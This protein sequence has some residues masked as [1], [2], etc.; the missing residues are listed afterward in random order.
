MEA[1]ASKKTSESKNSVKKTTPSTKSPPRRRLSR[2]PLASPDPPGLKELTSPKTP[3]SKTS[4]SHRRSF[5][6]PNTTIM[7]PL[8]QGAADAKKKADPVPRPSSTSTTTIRKVDTT[9]REV[10]EDR[11]FTPS[12]FTNILSKSV[13]PIQC[14]ARSYLAKKQVKERIMNIITVQ[15]IIRRYNCTRRY[16]SAQFIACKFQSM[17]R[18]M[19]VRDQLE[20]QHYCAGRVQSAWRGYIGTFVCFVCSFLYTV[21]CDDARSFCI[22]I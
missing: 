2:D 1:A 18:G 11:L 9:S 10:N 6:S 22:Y 15:S 16:K 14:L 8:L 3:Q 17:Y 13:V 12:N 19:I 5:S 21:T 4:S 20:F 7:S